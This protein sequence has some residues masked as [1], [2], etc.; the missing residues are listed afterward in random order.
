ML[1][2]ISLFVG[3]IGVYLQ[4]SLSNAVYLCRLNVRGIDNRCMEAIVGIGI[5]A[6]PAISVSLST[7]VSR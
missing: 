7:G 6:V 5:N 1:A 3:S 4:T 2:V